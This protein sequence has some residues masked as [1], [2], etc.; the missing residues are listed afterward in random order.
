V[1]LLQLDL[2]EVPP[3]QFSKLD[4]DPE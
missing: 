3:Q 1:S 2:V 4:F